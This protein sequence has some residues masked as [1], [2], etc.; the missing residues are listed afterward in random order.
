M[1]RR[2]DPAVHHDPLIKT[3]E[4]LALRQ[5]ATVEKS[6]RRGMRSVA[7]ASC[8]D[9]SNKRVGLVQSSGHLLYREHE[10]VT[11]S[12]ARMQCRASVSRI[13]D[14][15]PRG[16]IVNGRGESTSLRCS[17]DPDERVATAPTG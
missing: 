6:K 2:Y 7:W 5:P 1:A 4:L 10:R 13:C 17:H 8:P 12:G 16:L 3:R 11:L 15:P 14:N 9:C